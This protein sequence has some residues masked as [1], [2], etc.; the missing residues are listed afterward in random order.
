MPANGDRVSLWGD[1]NVLRLIVAVVA[2]H[3]ERT[4]CHGLVHFMVGGFMCRKFNLK[5]TPK[6]PWVRPAMVRRL[7]TGTQGPRC[8]EV[9]SDER[10]AGVGNGVG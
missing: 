4:E 5:K 9:G 3:C 7:D 1:E 10:G 2:Q 8:R 6:P